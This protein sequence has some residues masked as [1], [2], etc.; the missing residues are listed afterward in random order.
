M[1]KKGIMIL[2]IVL[3]LVSFLSG[4][5]TKDNN[6]SNKWGDAPDFT[7]KTLKGDTI[8]LSDFLGEVILLEFMG[9]DC[10][11]CIYQMPV[12]KAISE[13]Y[14]D[15]VIITV[16]IYPYETEA[17]LQS[18]IDA[19]DNELNMKLDWIFGKDKNGSISKDYVKDGGVPKLVIVDQNGNIY[20]SS[21][22]YTDYST[23]AVKLNN[24]LQ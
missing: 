1:N 3:L 18:L 23:I 11:Y 13:N 16:N 2:I 12:L 21:S 19:F 7:L 6:E 20:Y 15:L 5:T 17:Y 9:V 8:R 14:S 22:G 4:C 10:P 24:L